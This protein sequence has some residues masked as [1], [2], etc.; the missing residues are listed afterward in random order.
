[1]LVLK[2]S[3]YFSFLAFALSKFK[4]LSLRGTKISFLGFRLGS[5][6]GLSISNY[7]A[8]R[9]S[10]WELRFVAHPKFELN[11]CFIIYFRNIL[12]SFRVK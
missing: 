9:F 11:V 6:G 1:M 8:S 10:K 5:L 12:V 2:V 3:N 7:A 4:L